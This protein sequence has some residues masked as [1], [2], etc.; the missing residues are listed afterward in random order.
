MKQRFDRRKL[1]MT[2]ELQADQKSLYET[3]FVRW[4]ETV[5]AQLQA[6]DYASVDWAN[7]IEEIEEMSRRERK[8][9]KSNLVVILLYLLNGSISPQRQ[10][11]RQHSRTS[12]TEQR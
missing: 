6:Q 5:V 3:D 2:A 9:L 4:V 12:Q 1:V 10:L 11:A 7:L 8:S